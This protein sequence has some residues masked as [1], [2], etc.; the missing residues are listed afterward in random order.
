MFDTLGNVSHQAHRSGTDLSDASDRGLSQ[1]F[2][3][4]R[5]RGAH[6]SQDK[7]KSISA[8]VQIDHSLAPTSNGSFKLMDWQSVKQLVRD[9]DCRSV[10]N[11]VK[12]IVPRYVNIGQGLSLT[13]T[14][15]R[16]RFNEM[17]VG[18][19]AERAQRTGGAQRI[20]HQRA[21]PRTDLNPVERGWAS[22]ALP[23]LG[24]PQSNQFTE[25]LADFG[26]RDEIACG[27]DGVLCRVVPKFWISQRFRHIA[28]NR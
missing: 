6:R 15:H 1:G 9:D 5:E 25:Y 24:T 26:R 2:R 18:A 12:V 19:V 7:S 17:D 4:Q 11:L 14:Q 23:G 22:Q 28:I 27:T 16:A 20:P 21:S 3:N 13:F 8:R 10:R